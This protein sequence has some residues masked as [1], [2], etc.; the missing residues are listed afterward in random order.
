M[1]KVCGNIFGGDV[2]KIAIDNT[3]GSKDKVH[4][5]NEAK[6]DL[7]KLI[8]AEWD[9]LIEFFTDRQTKFNETLMEYEDCEKL[10]Y[11]VANKDDEK[12]HI[13]IRKLV[14]DKRFNSIIG[15]TNEKTK[16]IIKLLQKA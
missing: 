15:G 1:G 5:A 7:S 4:E 16:R 13:F 11:F 6:R 10:L 8:N 3:V 9:E 12:V 14:R 2:G